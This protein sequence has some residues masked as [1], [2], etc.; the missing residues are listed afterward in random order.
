[1]QNNELHF[2][3]DVCERFFRHHKVIAV[4]LDWS[5]YSA[6]S[7]GEVTSQHMAAYLPIWILPVQDRI[8]RPRAKMNPK[9]EAER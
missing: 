7:R 4:M 3:L 9:H 6:R 5:E 8:D 1:M 2:V